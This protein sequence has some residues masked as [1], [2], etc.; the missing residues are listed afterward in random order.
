MT[1]IQFYVVVAIPILGILTNTALFIHCSSRIDALGVR[2]DARID[3]IDRKIEAV[4]NM[5]NGDRADFSS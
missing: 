4:A 3:S 5:L 1:D 2:L